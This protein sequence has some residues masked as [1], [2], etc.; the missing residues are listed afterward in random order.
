MCSIQQLE[1]FYGRC[2]K[3]KAGLGMNCVTADFP[4]FSPEY[5]VKGPW[6]IKAFIREY[7]SEQI[8]F[9]QE[10]VALVSEVALAVNHQ[11]KVVQTIRKEVEE[12]DGQSFV[13]VGDGGIILTYITVPNTVFKWLDYAIQAVARRHA[14]KLPKLCYVDC[15]C[16]MELWVDAQKRICFGMGC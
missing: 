16:L 10:Q 11:W 14:G 13:I 5:V 2:C 7:L 4:P 15:N 1:D 12:I 3:K 6:L 8:Y 9:Q